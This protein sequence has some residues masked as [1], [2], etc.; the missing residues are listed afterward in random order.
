MNK[1]EEGLWEFEV[2]F[3]DGRVW[4]SVN[5]FYA[6]ALKKLNHVAIIMLSKKLEKEI[7][8]FKENDK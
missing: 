6:Q 1:N 2:K 3:V 4:I 5:K 7:P 8:K